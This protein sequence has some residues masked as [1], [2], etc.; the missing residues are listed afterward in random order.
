MPLTNQMNLTGPQTPIS[1]EHRIIEIL[2]VG[3]NL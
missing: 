3:T 2:V 1:P